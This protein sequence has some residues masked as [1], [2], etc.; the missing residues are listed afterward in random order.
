MPRSLAA[1]SGPGISSA[2]RFWVDCTINMAGHDLRQAQVA[3]I[4]AITTGTA[5][6]IMPTMTET[7]NI[8]S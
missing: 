2:A 7:K 6:V 4:M 8:E 3:I 5:I 1:L